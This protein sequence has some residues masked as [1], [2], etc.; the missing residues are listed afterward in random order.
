MPKVIITAHV[1]DAVKWE[2]AFRTHGELFRSQT[3]TKLN[4]G[5]IEGNEVALYAEVQDLDKYMKVL[6]SPAAADAMSFDG[7]KRDTVR[8]FVLDKEVDFD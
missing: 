3:I 8:L 4:I 1:E 6:D 2:E 7:V 5:T